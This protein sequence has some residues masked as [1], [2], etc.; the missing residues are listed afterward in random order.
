M[1]SLFCIAYSR[2]NTKIRITLL[3]IDVYA[4]RNKGLFNVI[5]HIV[6]KN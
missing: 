3:F 2:V 6:K 1:D 4:K 5:I